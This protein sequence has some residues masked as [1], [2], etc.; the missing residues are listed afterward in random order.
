MKILGRRLEGKERRG[1]GAHQPVGDTWRSP[2]RT[3][4]GAPD[5]SPS[6]PGPPP[7]GEGGSGWMRLAHGAEGAGKGGGA[8]WLAT[9]R[10]SLFFPARGNGERGLGLRARARARPFGGGSRNDADSSSWLF[11]CTRTRGCGEKVLVT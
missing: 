2:A 5:L 9:P 11:G 4:E 7:R 6:P 10:G 1:R 8:C 3:R